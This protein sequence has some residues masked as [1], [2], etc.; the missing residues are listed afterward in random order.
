MFRLTLERVAKCCHATNYLRPLLATLAQLE[1]IQVVFHA[2]TWWVRISIRVRCTTFSIHE[3]SVTSLHKGGIMFLIPPSRLSDTPFVRV[4]Q[5]EKNSRSRCPKSVLLIDTIDHI[6][7][8]DH[9]LL[10]SKKY[11]FILRFNS[12]SI[13]I[14][15]ILFIICT[16]F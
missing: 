13:W 4:I 7:I 12:S 15:Y 8:T 10:Y 6:H 5:L 1:L 2:V 11:A 3:A 14:T 16:R 9:Y